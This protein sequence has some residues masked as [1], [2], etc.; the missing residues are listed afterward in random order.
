MEMSNVKEIGEKIFKEADGAYSYWIAIEADKKT[1]F[2]K[3]AV[4]A[5]KDKRT[6]MELNK[7]PFGIYG[8]FTDK[9]K[10]SWIFKGNKQIEK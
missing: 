7:A 5:D 1:V 9:Y 6:F 4:G 8:Q 10:V 3:L 2:D